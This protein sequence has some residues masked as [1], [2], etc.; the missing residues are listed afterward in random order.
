MQSKEL[1]HA[2]HSSGPQNKFIVA[3]KS[4]LQHLCNKE[5][6]EDQSED[7]TTCSFSKWASVAMTTTTSRLVVV[8]IVNFSHINDWLNYNYSIN[9]NNDYEIFV[10]NSWQLYIV[11]Y[12]WATLMP[13][14]W[15]W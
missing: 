6:G 5:G 11:D 10:V 4:Q 7:D 13:Y 8:V 2:M 12:T 1:V 14:I 15:A 3:S 9:Y